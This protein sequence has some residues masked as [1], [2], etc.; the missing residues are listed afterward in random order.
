MYTG[1]LSL[2]EYVKESCKWMWEIIIIIKISSTSAYALGIS[3]AVNVGKSNVMRY[4]RHVNI[5][6]TNI[7]INW[8]PWEEIECLKHLGTLVVADGG[9]GRSTKGKLFYVQEPPSGESTTT[10][11]GVNYQLRAVI[12][13]VA[14][15]G[16]PSCS[17][18]QPA[19]DFG[20][21]DGRFNWL[22]APPP[23]WAVPPERL[24]NCI[25][26]CSHRE[27]TFRLYWFILCM[28]RSGSI[29]CRVH[30]NVCWVIED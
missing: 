18:P 6:W 4:S 10:E 23:S 13:E 17:R 12:I 14:Q 21:R 11:C 19:T 26:Q 8:E 25:N 28:R 2:V 20:A 27:S 5:G 24:V 30:R 29:R 22:V 3:H 1:E 16:T 9:C 15:L 7:R